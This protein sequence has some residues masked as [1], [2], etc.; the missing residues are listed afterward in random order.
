MLKHFSE[1]FHNPSKKLPFNIDPNSDICLLQMSG[2]GMSDK[3]SRASSSGGR[4]RV[5]KRCK[6][7][8]S[9]GKEFLHHQLNEHSTESIEVF[10]CEKCDYISHAYNDLIQHKRTLHPVNIPVGP[11]PTKHSSPRKE[12]SAQRAVNISGEIAVVGDGEA[13]F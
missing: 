4:V 3:P 11:S 5:C 6:F 8:T 13:L 2:S 7:S 12:T 10:A 9:D 1:T